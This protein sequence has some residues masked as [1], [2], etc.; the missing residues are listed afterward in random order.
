MSCLSNL[1]SASWLLLTTF[2]IFP[3]EC[4]T[5]LSA[6]LHSA[7]PAE[8]T[9]PTAAATRQHHQLLAILRT[10]AFT[11]L[12]LLIPYFSWC[13]QSIE[14]R[15]CTSVAAHAADTCSSFTARTLCMQEKN[16][17][18]GR[19]LLMHSWVVK[20]YYETI[21][22]IKPFSRKEICVSICVGKSNTA[23]TTTICRAL[24]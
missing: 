15:C 16:I 21:Y 8:M 19:C 13:A 1:F 22:N 12:Q 9:W 3:S 17:N 11:L 20:A 6:P 24:F 14:H 2:C 10:F 5:H 7:F 23:C 4:G 18:T